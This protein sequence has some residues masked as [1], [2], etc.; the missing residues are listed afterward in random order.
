MTFSAPFEVQTILGLM[1]YGNAILDKS[2]LASF[3]RDEKVPSPKSKNNHGSSFHDINS[4]IGS[5]EKKMDNKILKCSRE[6]SLGVGA[7][8]GG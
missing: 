5:R 2:S 8:M 6:F 4:F 1:N 3:L 7:K